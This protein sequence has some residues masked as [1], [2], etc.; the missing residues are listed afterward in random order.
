MWNIS[1]RTQCAL[2]TNGLLGEEGSR[3]CQTHSPATRKLSEEEKQWRMSM[4]ANA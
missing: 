4:A 1:M 2:I 3:E